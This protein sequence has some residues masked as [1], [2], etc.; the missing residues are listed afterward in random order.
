MLIDSYLPGYDFR[1]CRSILIESSST[2]IYQQLLVADLSRS[3][4]ITLLFR[5]RG[6]RP[7]FHTIRDLEKLGFTLLQENPG[8]EILFG[9]IT[10]HARFSDC[11][12][13]ITAAEF[14]EQGDRGT[15]KAVINFHVTELAATHSRISTETR[16]WCGSR[17]MKWKFSLYWLVVKPF[18]LWIRKLMLRQ[19]K[20][21]LERRS[22]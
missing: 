3:S 6:L 16:I 10:H 22:N 21:Q 15:I 12:P 13:G 9:M 19:L 17:G 11:R 2:A 18:S 14:L 1:T 20:R 7:D 8:E 4:T 5:L